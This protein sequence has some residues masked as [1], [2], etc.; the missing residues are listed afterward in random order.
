MQSAGCFLSFSSDHSRGAVWWLTVFFFMMPS[1]KG[2]KSLHLGRWNE[3]IR[4]KE[5]WN[6]LFQTVGRPGWIKTSVQMNVAEFCAPNNSQNLNFQFIKSNFFK[7]TPVQNIHVNLSKTNQ[8]SPIFL[9]ITLV[10]A[11]SQCSRLHT[12]DRDSHTR[13]CSQGLQAA[14][15]PLR[16]ISLITPSHLRVNAHGRTHARTHWCPVERMECHFEWRWQARW[17]M[18]EKPLQGGCFPFWADRIRT[19]HLVFWAHTEDLIFWEA[20]HT[21]KHTLTQSRSDEQGMCK[22]LVYKK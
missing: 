19:N 14:L 1:E 10:P 7:K 21:Y 18:G 20:H 5:V 3:G 12:I 16:S 13:P 2:V 8:T 22:S 4:G 6:L 17:V 11:G 9:N 15:P